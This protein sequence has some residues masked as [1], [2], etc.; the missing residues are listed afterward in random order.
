MVEPKFWAKLNL[1]NKFSQQT[2]DELLH[3]NNYCYYTFSIEADGDR[4]IQ[5]LADF[6]EATT[7]TPKLM[8]DSIKIICEEGDQKNTQKFIN[9]YLDKGYDLRNIST[10]WD[11]NGEVEPTRYHTRS[12]SPKL[13]YSE[14]AEICEGTHLVSKNVHTIVYSENAPTEWRNEL[15]EVKYHTLCLE[16]TKN[17][18]EE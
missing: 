12:N 8:F 18:M 6:L 16:Y 10:F 5:C 4:S 17:I 1:S 15:K 13:A 14:A 2:M 7:I 9:L 11:I 3:N